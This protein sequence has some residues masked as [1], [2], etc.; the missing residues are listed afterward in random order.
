VLA[1]GRQPDAGDKAHD[2][3][4]LNTTSADPAPSRR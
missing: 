3:P 1:I 2:G 4:F